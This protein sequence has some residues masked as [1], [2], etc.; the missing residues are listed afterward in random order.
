MYSNNRLRHY[1]TSPQWIN[2]NRVSMCC[3]GSIWTFSLPE[4]F[5]W[6][7]CADAAWPMTIRLLLSLYVLKTQK[8]VT[9]LLACIITPTKNS[10]ICKV[11]GT[12]NAVTLI[13]CVTPEVGFAKNA[14]LGMPNAVS[15]M[16][17][18]IGKDFMNRAGKSHLQFLSGIFSKGQWVVFAADCHC[19]VWTDACRHNFISCRWLKKRLTV[20]QSPTQH[21]HISINKMC[22]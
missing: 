16:K 9:L 10:Q 14:W 15:T 3:W 19:V 8:I 4:I 20:P 21:H 7:L 13:M 1:V 11:D 17:N 2:Q 22:R 5:L 6:I 18:C 12:V